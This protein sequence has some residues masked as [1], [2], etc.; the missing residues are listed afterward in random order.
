[1]PTQIFP[2]DRPTAQ[3]PRQQTAPRQFAGTTPLA[4]AD[5]GGIY[6]ST[7]AAQY[8]PPAGA[9]AALPTQTAQLQRR[10]RHA[11][12][13]WLI[14][15]LCVVVLFGACSFFVSMLI[16]NRLSRRPSVVVRGPAVPPVPAIPPI[17]VPPNMGDADLS[18]LTPLDESGADVSDD[19]TVITKTFPL[20]AGATFTLGQT[21]GDVTVEGW[22]G[23]GAQVKITKEGGDE[24]D[25]AAA[26]I[27]HSAT[28]KGLT[29]RTPEG[30]DEVKE[31]K[32]EIKLPR[33]VRQIEINSR[34]SDVKLSNLA[35]GVSVNVLK[36]DLTASQLTGRVEMRTMKGDISVDLKGATPAQPQGFNTVRGDVTL[37]VDGANADVQAET[38]AGGAS[39]DP[40]LGIAVEKQLVGARAAGTVGKGG[41]EIV[42]K[43]VRGDVRIK[44]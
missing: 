43:T 37:A 17:P 21:A 26:R 38:V 44:K 23:D 2:A 9:P 24:D 30:T 14:A 25:R 33:G 3:P 32:Y 16:A 27:L 10:K 7:F 8:Q 15:I 31:F 36:G 28:D 40:G 35:G 29:L 11:W 34:Q 18:G 39:A 42:A 5:T 4:G 12:R 20:K 13:G 19:K 6:H 41:Q 22:D 1:M